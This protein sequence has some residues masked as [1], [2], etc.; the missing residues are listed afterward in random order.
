[1]CQNKPIWHSCFL[2]AV[3]GFWYMLLVHCFQGENS[4]RK[5][6]CILLFSPFRRWMMCE[7]NSKNEVMK[8]FRDEGTEWYR[9]RGMERC[10]EF[11]V[12][13]IR[14]AY[15]YLQSSWLEFLIERKLK[16]QGSTW[17]D[18]ADTDAELISETLFRILTSITHTRTLTGTQG[19]R[20]T[21]W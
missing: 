19:D 15:V 3:T 5:Y 2:A 7:M 11:V 6:I 12:P 14:L 4:P 8:W 1:M 20:Q 13:E 17:W 21:D 18:W 10:E 9:E 16:Y